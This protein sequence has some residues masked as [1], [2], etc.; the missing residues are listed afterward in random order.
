M[1]L[2]TMY[3]DLSLD[4]Q[5]KVTDSKQCTQPHQ[6]PALQQ[7]GYTTPRA[8][9]GSGGGVLREIIALMHSV[10][11]GRRVNDDVT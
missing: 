3:H 7:H 9:Y 2:C 11:T 4:I 6:Q 8:R 1:H 5:A 10:V